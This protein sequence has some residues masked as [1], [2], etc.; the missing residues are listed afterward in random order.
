MNTE[1]L[2]EALRSLSDEDREKVMKQF[3]RSCHT[4]LGE[5]IC[6][7]GQNYCYMCSPD[8]RED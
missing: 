3:C 1:Q 2:V 5:Q 6:W 8:P 4:F 7:S